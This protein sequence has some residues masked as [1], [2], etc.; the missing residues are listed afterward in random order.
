MQRAAAASL[1]LVLLL[2]L[3]AAW[4]LLRHELVADTASVLAGRGSADAAPG[5]TAESA[6]GHDAAAPAH[7][8]PLAVDAPRATAASQ[9]LVAGRAV[10]AADGS[11][12]AGILLALPGTGGQLARTRPGR[13]F[14]FEQ[15][16]AGDRLL[17]SL[18]R[19]GVPVVVPMPDAQ[20]DV[21]ALDVV[22]DTGWIQPGFVRDDGGG[23]LPGAEVSMAMDWPGIPDFEIQDKL[24]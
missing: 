24:L 4:W 15:A 11:P 5:F 18:P 3:A 21:P 17:G 8:T 19:E 7:V 10:R 9:R 22:L 20:A 1:G 23:P 6:D 14:G 12:L 2:A 16:P 13:A